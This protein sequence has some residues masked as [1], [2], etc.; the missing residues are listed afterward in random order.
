MYPPSDVI[1]RNNTLPE[2]GIQQPDLVVMHPFTQHMTNNHVSI[3]AACAIGGCEQSANVNNTVTRTVILLA[4]KLNAKNL[5]FST[6]SVASY[7][8]SIYRICNKISNSNL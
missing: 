5:A 8:E 1:Q 4:R 7:L 3:M 2:D 6:P